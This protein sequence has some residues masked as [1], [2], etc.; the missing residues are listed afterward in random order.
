MLF[1]SS[2]RSRS[3]LYTD[4]MRAEALQHKELTNALERALAAGQ[5]RLEYQP[6][7]STHSSRV[8]GA[9]ALLRWDHPAR[10]TLHPDEFLHLAEASGAIVPIGDWVVRQS[11]SD[12]RQWIDSGIVDRSF[13]VHVNI[14]SRQLVETTFV[15]RVLATVRQTELSPQ[16]LT[17]DF[18]ESTLNDRHPGITRSLQA[19]RRFGV[20]LALDGFGTGV[21]SLNALRTCE[22]DVLKL[23]GGEARRLGISG[24]DDPVV[25]AIVQLAHALDMQVVAEWVTT[26]DQLRR[27]RMLGC[28]LV[29]GNLVGMPTGAAAFADLVR[30]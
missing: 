26:P 5:L 20:R 28:D 9:E 11:C 24:D 3:E 27:L 13:S 1:R 19:L 15:E 6:I 7:M 21:S 4:E 25:R 14:S 18:D 23:D 16:Q 29:Q 8:V 10:G 2:G 22:A 30:R 17:L 12:T